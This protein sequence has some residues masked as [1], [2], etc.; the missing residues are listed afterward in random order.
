MICTS[1]AGDIR[2]EFGCYFLS[3]SFRGETVSIGDD[4]STAGI[5]VGG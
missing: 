5:I 1:F 3:S 4:S 2:G